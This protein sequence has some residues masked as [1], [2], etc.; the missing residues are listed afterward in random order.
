M[1]LRSPSEINTFWFGNDR[2]KFNDPSHIKFTMGKWF[3]RTVPEVE[4][5]FMAESEQI[6]KLTDTASLTEEWFS[7]EGKWLTF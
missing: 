6:D 5:T 7:P 4:T 3:A 1:N 2:A